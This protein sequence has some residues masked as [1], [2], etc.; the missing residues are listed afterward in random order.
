MG[1][2]LEKVRTTTSSWSPTEVTVPLQVALD[3]CFVPTARGLRV[4]EANLVVVGVCPLITK[5]LDTEY[6]CVY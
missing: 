1:V 5:Q 6:L 2:E 4:D 3:A